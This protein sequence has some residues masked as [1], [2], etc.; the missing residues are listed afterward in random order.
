M[1]RLKIGIFGCNVRGLCLARDFLKNNCDIVAAC[2]NRE[3]TKAEF[4]S[5]VG[6][7]CVWYSDFD[8]FVLHKMDAVVLTNNFHQ[9]APYAI[10]CFERGL[11][12][13]SE[14]ISNCTLGEGVE[15]IRA[16][17]KSNVVYMLAENYP[18][19]PVNLEMQK[20]CKEGSLGKILYAEGEYNH[21]TDPFDSSFLN[22]YN[23]TTSHWRNYLPATYYL[24]HS[25]G[26]IMKATGA[27]PKK[28][29][30]FA[31]Y[32]P[33][34]PTRPT[35]KR[36]PEIAVITTLNDDGSVFRFTGCAAFGA[37]HNSYR[38][39]GNNGSVENLRGMGNKIMLRYNSWSIPKGKQEVNLYDARIDDKEKNIIITSQHDG[40]DYLTV[41]IFVD[42]IRAK[43]QPPF[44]FDIYSAVTMSAVAYFAHMSLLQNGN[45]FEIPDFKN[46]EVLS[47]Y[48]NCND[49]PFYNNDGKTP[50][51]PCCA[52]NP[53]YKPSKKQLEMFCQLLK[54]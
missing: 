20:V 39:C 10:K 42:S 11:H 13:F 17:E 22:D 37:H 19:M 34:E 41:R 45:T 23:Y 29:H 44:P 30:S 46:K 33:P 1:K 24:T 25:L 38:I 2:D 53:D 9:H 21:P 8:N 54:D 15:L 5:A 43:T 4:L 51:L 40:S 12:V 52:A 6:K 26:P 31:I 16:F 48:E 49:S 7:E 47:Q 27:S 50:T 3:Q 28:V 36:C 32:N 18:Q 35:V 14:C